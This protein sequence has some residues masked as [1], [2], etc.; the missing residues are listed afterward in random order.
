MPE[1][2]FSGDKQPEFAFGIVGLGDIDFATISLA[3]DNINLVGNTFDAYQS[4]MSP[5]GQR[6]IWGCNT[7][8]DP[9]NVQQNM[10][11][12]ISNASLQEREQYIMGGN[13]NFA[14]KGMKPGIYE[15]KVVLI[16]RSNGQNYI[17]E[18][19]ATYQ[20]T[21][22]QEKWGPHLLT[23]IL[24]IVG[25]FLIIKYREWRTTRLPKQRRK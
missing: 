20:I 7:A 3:S 21:N 6:I 14:T 13:V 8:D 4:I 18:D 12:E 2:I 19:I 16:V 1:K 11:Y 24:S 9:E 23:W 25:S 10:V 17:S 22:W 5:D 15:L